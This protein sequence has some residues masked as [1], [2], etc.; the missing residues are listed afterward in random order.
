MIKEMKFQ[1]L[2]FLVFVFII[3]LASPLSFEISGD[4]YRTT[5]HGV[6]VSGTFR[7]NNTNSTIN[8][9]QVNL[10]SLSTNLT[11]T[12]L[13]TFSLNYS[14]QKSV[15]YSIS[16]PQYLPGGNY[17]FSFNIQ[18]NNGTIIVPSE[19]KFIIVNISDS[20]SLTVSSPTVYDNTNKTNVTV[21]NNGNKVL[22]VTL[23]VAS[24]SGVSFSIPSPNVVIGPGES[25]N[26]LVHIDASG[27]G[28]K[29]NSISHTITASAQGVSATGKLSVDKSYCRYGIL[30]DLVRI[31]DVDD[32]SSGNDW[33]WEPLKKVRV[34][35]DVENRA[36]SRESITVKLGLY[37]SDGKSVWLSTDDKELDQTIRIQD[38]DDAV[39]DFEFTLPADLKRNEDYRLYVKAYNKES[40]QCTNIYKIIDLDTDKDVIADDFVIPSFLLCGSTNTISFRL[41]NLDLGDEEIMRARLYS[42][43]LGLDIVSEQFELDDGDNRYVYFNVIVPEGKEAKSYRITPYAEYDYRDSSDTFRASENLGIFSIRVEGDKCLNKATSSIGVKLR[44]NTLTQVGEELIVDLLINN[45]SETASFLV[46]LEGYDAWATSAV[47]DIAS[48]NLDKSGTKSITATIVPKKSG[49]QEFTVKTISNGKISEQKV[50]VNIEEGSSFIKDAFNSIKENLTFYLTISIFIVLTL[51]ILIILIRFINSSKE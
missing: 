37:D 15:S 6:S 49:T 45:P 26:L 21:F 40:E 47:L 33:E 31:I 28:S 7:L 11:F 19:T 27:M 24:S 39:F 44:E 50:T 20:P 2:A 17:T 34:R 38:N 10:T 35:V 9:T 42:S 43:E 12:T 18:A 22:S 36:D 8:F 41:Y 30:G 48:F 1:V 14:E 51:I 29:I 16:I 13:S 4:T 5:T 32:R 3:G 46:V 25:K 23:S